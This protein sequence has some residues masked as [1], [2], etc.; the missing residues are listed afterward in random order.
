MTSLALYSLLYGNWGLFLLCIIGMVA[1]YWVG[2][3][4]YVIR[5]VQILKENTVGRAMDKVGVA[6]DAI[7]TAKR[8]T[9][10]AKDMA[11]C[12]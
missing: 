1:L 3:A 12:N 10:V 11:K 4:A 9:E 7:D 8:S 6:K 5:K 2:Y